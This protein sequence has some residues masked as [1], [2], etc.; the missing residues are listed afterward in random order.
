MQLEV[1]LATL[2]EAWREVGTLRARRELRCCESPLQPPFITV[3]WEDNLRALLQG[4]MLSKGEGWRLQSNFSGCASV[5]EWLAGGTPGDES[6]C[7]QVL[8]TRS[9]SCW[10]PT[11]AWL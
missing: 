11:G 10:S 7:A 5:T 6:M 1:S 8:Y 4:L 9:A 2:G 3:H